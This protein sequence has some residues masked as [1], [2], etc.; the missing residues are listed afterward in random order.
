MSFEVSAVPKDDELWQNL[1]SLFHVTDPENLGYGRDVRSSENYT[2]LTPVCAWVI[3]ADSRFNKYV[4]AVQELQEGI[5]SGELE[6]PV[7]TTKL[8]AA[9]EKLH[10]NN[11]T[12]C[13]NEKVL[14]HGTRPETL[15]TLLQN[16]LSE[17]FSKGLFGNG[18][19]L[20]E[21]PSKIDQYCT[22]DT[23]EG[24]GLDL[25]HQKL[26][27]E[28]DVKPVKNMFYA[29]VCRAALGFPV[30]TK[31]AKTNLEPPHNDIF[32][33]DER[34]ELGLIPESG[35]LP[36]HY[37][38]LI[39]EKG[40]SSEGYQCARHREFVVF[41]SSRI[42][43]EYI[44]G[45][46]RDIAPEY[47]GSVPNRPATNDASNEAGD[48]AVQ[49]EGGGGG[50]SMP[51]VPAPTHLFPV[52][53]IPE[54]AGIAIAPCGTF[55]LVGNYKDDPTMPKVGHIDLKT[56]KL[57]FPYEGIG[58]MPFSVAIASNGT[59]ALVANRSN[60]HI[61]R[62]DLPSGKVT[63]EYA[64]LPE[65][66]YTPNQVAISPSGMFA[67]V[68][69]EQGPIDAT[70]NRIVHI[71]L[72]RVSKD[73]VVSTP[74]VDL[75]FS[76]QGIAIAPSGDYAI[77]SGANCINRLE[78][79]AAKNEAGTALTEIHRD[80]RLQVCSQVAMAPSGNFVLVAAGCDHARVDLRTEEITFV[81]NYKEDGIGI[82]D[83][84][85]LSIAPSETFALASC[86][87]S[88]SVHCISSSAKCWK[89]LP[90][91]DYTMDEEP[92]KCCCSVM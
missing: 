81:D 2:G 56:G 79:D 20:A 87:S 29:I 35:E 90:A 25:L 4:A 23:Q 68:A 39:A 42:I 6:I 61:S 8:D 5:S 26:F 62:I 46:I 73:N 69:C 76:P 32:A 12:E 88:A 78:L 75:D 59:F 34:R 80:G 7:I 27:E 91:P 86:S 21:D 51:V 19:Y 13:A 48:A 67:L 52:S 47:P 17:R 58:G 14:L 38:S 40:P 30:Y 54:A 70:E 22:P 74:Y 50:P 43:E 11:L 41:D 33:N 45:Y 53:G 18:S 24:E 84:M 9:G 55:A 71:Q 63:E 60:D 37:H 16:G 92:N 66:F 1:Y 57:T 83:P 36:I 65:G 3:D 31:D 49:A 72:S 85:C 10:D 77:I 44:I 28:C 15:L 64:K 89:P 82:K